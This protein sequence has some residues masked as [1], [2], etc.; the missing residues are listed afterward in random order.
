MI[1]TWKEGR[2]FY[3]GISSRGILTQGSTK[4]IAIRRCREELKAKDV[5]MDR[6]A[7]EERKI[8]AILYPHENDNLSS[9]PTPILRTEINRRLAAT[10]PK[11]KSL[12]PC[13]GCQAPLSARERRKPCPHCGARNP[14]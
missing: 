8:D 10:S 9:I 6:D 5:E 14:R 11:P 1:S 3:A 2:T 13:V 7:A 4:E 12:A